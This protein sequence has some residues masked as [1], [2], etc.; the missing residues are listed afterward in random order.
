MDVG[1]RRH[2]TGLDRS[3][4]ETSRRVDRSQRHRHARASIPLTVLA[5]Q[6]PFCLVGMSFWLRLP[7][8]SRRDSPP[9]R[10]CRI[11]RIA[12]CSAPFSHELVVQ[13]VEAEGQ[14]RPV[15]L[16]PHSVRRDAESVQGSKHPGWQPTSR[17]ISLADRRSPV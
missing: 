1:A 16:R 5:C 4:K 7:A 13:V 11:I 8:I 3:Q 14:S 6:T 12:A 9:A 15:L 2:T 17:E 10:Y